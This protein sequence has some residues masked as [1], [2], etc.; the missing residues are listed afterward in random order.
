MAKENNTTTV[1]KADITDFKASMQEAARLVRLANS[2]FKAATAGMDDWSSTTDGLTAKTTQLNR[3]LDAQKRQLDTLETEYRRVAAEQGED[4]I[5]AQ[6]L[7][8]RINNQRA[9]IGNTESQ[10]RTY[11]QRLDDVTDAT[12]EAGEAAEEAANG[13]FTVFKGILANL[14]TEVIKQ[15]VA[16]L[17]E[18]TTEAIQTGLSF[19]RS[20]SKVAALSGATGDELQ[21]LTDTARQYGATTQFSASE[22]AD[23]LGYMAL[24]GWDAQQSAAELGGVLNL[25]AASGMELAEASDMVTDYLSAFSNSAMTAGQFADK[26]AYAQAN[27]NTSATQLGQAYRNSAANLNAAGQDVETVTALLSAMANQGLKG[28]KAGT[29]LS[30]MMRDLTSAMEEVVDE[31]DLAKF[32][33]EGMTDMIGKQIIMIGDQAIAVSD[34][35]GNFRDLT[36]ILAEVEAATAS[37]GDAERASAVGSVFT[38]DSIKGLNLVMNEGIGKTAAFE[39]ELRNCEGAAADMSG[40]MTNNLSGDLKNI[41]SAFQ[42]FQL[43][44]YESVNSPLRDMAQSVSKEILPALTD[45][46]NGVEGADKVFGD[47]VGGL[48]GKGVQAIVEGAPKFASAGLSIVKTLALS[49]VKAAPDVVRSGVTI[50]TE[51][52]AMLGTFVPELLVGILQAV[53]Q[54]VTTI[55]QAAP[56]VIRAVFGV[57]SSVI[58]ALPDVIGALLAAFPEVI[59]ALI[60]VM[61]ESQTALIEGVTMVI[62]AISDALPTL[63]PVIVSGLQTLIETLLPALISFSPELLQAEITLFQ[64]FVEALPIVTVEILKALPALITAIVTAIINAAP[65]LKKAAVEMFTA[66]LDGFKQVGGLI[67]KW[68]GQAWS[69]FSAWAAQVLAAAK[70]AAPKV[71]EAVS[72]F[73]RDLPSNLGF[74]LGY[75]IGK[76]YTFVTDSKAKAK[77]AGEGFRDKLVEFFQKLPERIGALLLDVIKKIPS[78][79][80]ALKKKAKEAGESFRDNILP[81][82]KELPGKTVEIGRNI[83][84]GIWDGIQ[85]MTG[86]IKG[87]VGEFSSGFLD[88]FKSALGISSPSKVMR[89][90]VGK[91]LALGIADGFE[92]EIPETLRE[93]QKG[94]AEIV[95]G[96]TD[97]LSV[98][99]VDLGIS[100]GSVKN[101]QGLYGANTQGIGTDGS[102]AG[103]KVQNV[104]FNQYNTSPKALDRLSI[105]RDTNSMLFAAKVRLG[106]V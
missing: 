25:A 4:S 18:L 105:Y 16:G 74:Y 14:A 62:S 75:A 94:A 86:W 98:P 9:A 39:E 65:E 97:D 56:D 61:M 12:E 84:T 36:E 32:R 90:Q 81:F 6:E 68:L 76:L 93:M 35:E 37:M 60:T 80:D 44:L 58:R 70:E 47:A 91:W 17:K 2:E 73:F 28:A 100:A 45:M 87:K 102:A 46:L 104:T 23:A 101:V 26:L 15:A 88:G 92:G 54:I 10:L 49:I 69:V 21:M 51:L 29:A 78:F 99:L 31:E 8:I 57:V 67:K 13:G 30:A 66:A 55:A 11:E 96:L 7:Q 85:E 82:F 41:N 103:A 33:I 64:T 63:L 77:E 59:Q 89:D 72:Q 42:E 52:L 24:A 5:A 38:A 40:T 43:T 34:A 3:I 50:L 79:I 48:I 20:M 19:E 83:V 53:P 1:F 27:S 95:K 22:A 106:D 71:L